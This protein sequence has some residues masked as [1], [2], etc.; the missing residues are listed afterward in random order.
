MSSNLLAKCAIVSL[1]ICFSQTN[2]AIAQNDLSNFD[3]VRM[4]IKEAEKTFLEKNLSLIAEHY[5]VISDQALI[6]QAKLWDNPSLN[7]DQNL[8]TNHKFF[9]HSK[10]PDGTTNGQ[11]YVQIQQLIKTA[12][13]RG[14]EIKL[15][16]TNAQISEWQFN[17][18]MRN[19]KLQFRSDFYTAHQLINIQTLYTDEIHQ[20][21]ILI[22][23][24]K[25]QYQ[26]GNI[27]EK[28]LLRIQALKISTQ[29]DAVDNSNKLMDVETELKSLLQ[30]SNNAIV[31]PTIETEVNLNTTNL[32]L[33]D[34]EEKA[35][36]YNAS[37]QL[38]QL[39][40]TYQKQNL[41][42]QKSLAIPDITLGPNYDKN[43][44]YIQNYVGLGISLPIP[45]FDRNQGNIHSAK[46]LVKEQETNLQQAD[47]DLKNNVTNAFYKL[48]QI[49]KLSNNN[50]A[51]FY[52]SY[53]KLYHNIMESYRQ[54]QISLIEFIDYFN[55]YKDAHENELQ[56]QLNLQLSKE[57]LNYQVGIDVLP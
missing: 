54:R 57:E 9:D 26:M 5:H 19:L 34:L 56:Q 38:Q 14:K 35:K 39:Q 12:N 7:T 8:Y 16:K 27:A 24:M 53:D 31:V 28:D 37:Y 32:S 18:L 48:L 22:D 21:D 6:Q 23:A 13:K 29:Q 3:T 30:L 20:L 41:S 43:S 1:I 2:L 45:L 11:Y 51:A 17:D 55:A 42:L 36:Q 4:N 49:K 10:N 15:A 50:T 46:W 52:E 40:L 33:T 44:N 25:A 47:L